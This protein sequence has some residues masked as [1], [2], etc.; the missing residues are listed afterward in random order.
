MSKTS[1]DGF[2]RRIVPAG[3][4]VN[5]WSFDERRATEGDGLILELTD[6]TT[7][8]LCYPCIELLPDDPTETDV[9]T[10]RKRDLEHANRPVEDDPTVSE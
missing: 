3:S 2:G 6:E 5:V 8:E 1:C 4:I 7:H 9:E 10:L